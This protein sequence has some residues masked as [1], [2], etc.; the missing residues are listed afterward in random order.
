[1]KK[2]SLSIM[3]E[4]FSFNFFFSSKSIFSIRLLSAAR[5]ALLSRL[6]KLQN[7]LTNFIHVERVSLSH[8]LDVGKYFWSF[9]M[10]SVPPEQQQQSS[11]EI[12]ELAKFIQYI[13]KCMPLHHEAAR[14]C[15]RPNNLLSIIWLRADWVS[16]VVRYELQKIKLNFCC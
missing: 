8:V 11:N 14:E 15:D 3:F 13:Y 7:H 6:T 9:Q 10:N 1:M 4:M 5:S 16:C 12:L 2:N